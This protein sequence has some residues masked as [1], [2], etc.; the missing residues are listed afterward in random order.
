[1]RVPRS[2]GRER[3]DDRNADQFRQWLRRQLRS[4]RMSL[5]Q[6]A[7]HSGVSAS[8]VSRVVSNKYIHTPRGLFPM[9]YFF[10]SG[11]DSAN[12]ADVSSL[13]IKNKIAHLIADEDARRPQSDARI[14]QRLR[15]EGIQIARRTVAKYREELRIPSSSQRKQSF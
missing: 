14:M 3:V 11:I 8:T 4:R 1:M 9:K 12:G 6:L 2:N 7:A 5:R 15:A 10:H 13:S